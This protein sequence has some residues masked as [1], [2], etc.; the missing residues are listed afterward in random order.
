VV[1]DNAL[2]VP[3]SAPGGT[4]RE[5]D[6]VATGETFES[7]L[8]AAQTGAD[9]AFEVLYDDYNPRLL[10]YFAARAPR[11]AEDLAS[12]TWMGVAS[13]LRSFE[14]GEQHFRSWL[15]TIA[16]RRLVDHWRQR[17]D[18]P[19]DLGSFQRV[20]AAAEGPEEIV[21]GAAGAQAAA[22]RIASVLSADQ[23]E[24]ILLRVLGGLDVEEVAQILGKRA[25]TIRVLQHRALRK[26]ADEISLEDVTR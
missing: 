14:G 12:E 18:E 25:G 26:L 7:V 21:L 15:F 10:R 23:A 17:V 22:R 3:D 11:A 5:N 8:A 13:G 20:E 24:V 1:P 4:V 16:H 9:W 19:S 2:A 6:R